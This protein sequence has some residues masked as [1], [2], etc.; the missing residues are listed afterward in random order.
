MEYEVQLARVDKAVVVPAGFFEPLCNSCSSPDCTNPIHEKTI[1]V[2]GQI[3]KQRLY[4][5][6]ENVIRQVIA[7]KG[8]VGDAE[9]PAS[10]MGT[11]PQGF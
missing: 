8:Y 2:A 7:C 3:K 5:M 10:P 6:N 11:Q 4:I 9:I 1:S